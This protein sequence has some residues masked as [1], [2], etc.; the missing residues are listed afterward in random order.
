[1]TG[2]VLK[3]LLHHGDEELGAARYARYDYSDISPSFFEKAQETFQSQV[4][5]MAFKVLNIEEDPVSQGMEEQYYDIVI[6]SSVSISLTK[7]NEMF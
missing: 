4:G 5:R 7:S 3:S 1:M 2:H 6:A